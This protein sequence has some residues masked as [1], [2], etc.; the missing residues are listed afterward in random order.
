LKRACIIITVLPHADFPFF[1]YPDASTDDRPANP[2]TIM[3]L[4]AQIGLVAAIALA[5]AGGWYAFQV[6]AGDDAPS[7][8]P[9]QGRAPTVVA[10]EARTGDIAVTFNAVGTLR[11]N[12]AVTVTSKLS[13]I[14]KAIRFDEGQ[15][16]QAGDVLIELDDTEARAELAVAESQR[17][18]VLQDLERSSALLGRQAVAQARVDDL[19]IEAQGA[20]AR[21]NAAR[22]RLQDLTIRAPFAGVTGIRHVSPGALVRPGDAVTTLDDVSTVKLEFAVPET[23]LSRLSQGMRITADSAAY[24]GETF[25]GVVEVIDTRVDP[26]SRTL[27]V[28]A[29]VPNPQARLKPGMFMSVDL[30]LDRLTGV[31]LIPEEALVPVGDRQF[32]F[33]VVDGKVQRRPVQ[34]GA[35]Q[36]GMV[37]VR[38]GVAAGDLVITRGVQKVRDGAPVTVEVAPPLATA[39]GGAA[40]PVQTL[41][42]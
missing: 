23:A 25:D 17:R 13:G 39:V 12:E 21:V 20:E 7:A 1:G 27:A 5:G 3:R 18:T 6:G 19:R 2:G 30:T 42:Q 41:V 37:Q 38:D 40:G 14:V 32:V 4:I 22:A 29:A 11:A 16:V 31:V 36:R 26:V 33:A 35:R 28:V 10:A 15:R 8:G 34:I 9:A 24:Q